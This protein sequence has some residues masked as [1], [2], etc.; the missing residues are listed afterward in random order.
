MTNVPVQMA[1]PCAE[2]G[3]PEIGAGL[4]AS[5]YAC[6]FPF[7]L[8]ALAA[9]LHS[10]PWSAA[11]APARRAVSMNGRVALVWMLVCRAVSA[12]GGVLKC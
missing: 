11:S 3:D 7:L 1:L 2:P 12:C 10:Q 8:F 5:L 4:P 6:G 9:Q